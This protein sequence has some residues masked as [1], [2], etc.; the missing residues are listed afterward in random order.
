MEKTYFVWYNCKFI[1]MY[2]SLK[3]ALGFILKR[4]LKDDYNNSLMI[5]DNFG[6]MYD[7]ISGKEAADDKE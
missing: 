3:R 5:A 4:G 1:A 7:P 6:N 2:K